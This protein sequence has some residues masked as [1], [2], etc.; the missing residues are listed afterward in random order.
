MKRKIAVLMTIVMM[1]IMIPAT[2]N[3]A[4]N[5]VSMPSSLTIY[6]KQGNKWIRTG[7]ITYTYDSNGDMTRMVSEDF[8]KKGKVTYKEVSDFEYT[9]NNDGSAKIRTE[10]NDYGEGDKI[11]IVN[12]HIVKEGY[13]DDYYSKSKFIYDKKGRLKKI[14]GIGET[15]SYKYSGR[16]KKIYYGKKWTRTIKYN[17]SGYMIYMKDD[18]GETKTTYKLNKNKQVKTQIATTK[19]GKETYKS[20][21]VYKYTKEKKWSLDYYKRAI[22]NDSSVPGLI[23]ALG[24]Y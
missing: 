14:K 17:K 1:L 18:R 19:I 4:S 12:D 3:A 7:M 16:T 9:Y 13:S 6:A 5:K 22:N 23:N 11:K 10:H 21:A 2:S 20:K 8:N 15:V 24:A